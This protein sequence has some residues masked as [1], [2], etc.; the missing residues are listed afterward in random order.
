MVCDMTYPQQANIAAKRNEK[1]TKYQQ[2]AFELKERR[3]GYD[4]TIVIGTL[5]GGIK[6]VLRDVGRVFSK[7]LE[8]ERLIEITVAEMLLIHW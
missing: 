7:C 3:P 6:E 2:L 5:G 1:V 4:I 8:R